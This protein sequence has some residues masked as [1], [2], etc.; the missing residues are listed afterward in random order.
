MMIVCKINQKLI[1]LLQRQII[2]KKMMIYFKERL[3]SIEFDKRK[4]MPYL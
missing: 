1:N 3:F 2:H 4:K